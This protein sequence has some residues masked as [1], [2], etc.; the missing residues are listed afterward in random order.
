MFIRGISAVALPFLKLGKA[1]AEAA[2]AGIRQ[3]RC[4]RELHEERGA[5]EKL[6]GGA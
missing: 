2:A 6:R 4:A 5:C 1:F 3:G